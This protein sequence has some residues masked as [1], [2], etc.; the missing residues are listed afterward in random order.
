VRPDHIVCLECGAKQKTLKRHLQVA[1]GLSVEDYR[2]KWSLPK[3]YPMVAP[4]YAAQRSALAKQLGLGRQRT[5]A[6]EPTGEEAA[7]EATG[8][9]R[10]RGRKAA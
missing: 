1:H 6:A 3:D 5:G 7:P 10:R 9:S 4:D 2:A 8:K